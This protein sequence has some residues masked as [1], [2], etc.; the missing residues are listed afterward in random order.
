MAADPAVAE[1]L[2][3]GA[4]SA[5]D[6]SAAMTNSGVN[7]TTTGIETEP[8]IV[9]VP[10]P[11]PVAEDKEFHLHVIIGAGIGA[12]LFAVISG[13]CCLRCIRRQRVEPSASANGRY[14]KKLHQDDSANEPSYNN[15]D[16]LRLP[17]PK[18]SSRAESSVCVPAS[19]QQEVRFPPPKKGARRAISTECGLP[20]LKNKS[21]SS[22]PNT[23][24][25]RHRG[26]KLTERVPASPPS[27]PPRLVGDGG[28][29]GF[30]GGTPE[31][32]VPDV[33]STYA[34]A[35]VHVGQG[36]AGVH[37]STGKHTSAASATA[38]TAT[39][40]TLRRINAIQ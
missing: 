37:F 31:A 8:A 3:S 16:K 21:G 28:S 27:E 15:D 11:P 12:L 5:A 14:R 17:L 35:G 7:A 24:A 9:D 30:G 40:A 29:V 20:S 10:S 22:L 13:I 6:I 32:G 19:L 18:H 23:P 25:T 1:K 33:C 39:K 34:E 4:I 26:A 36:N 38:T 2:T